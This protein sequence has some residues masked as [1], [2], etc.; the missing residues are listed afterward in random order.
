MERFPSA[1]ATPSLLPLA[2]CASQAQAGP[3]AHPLPTDPVSFHEVAFDVKAP[4]DRLVQ[5]FL[6]APLERF[7]KGTSK[8]PGVRHTEPLTDLRYPAVGSVRLVFL[9]DGNTAHEEV[10]TCDERQLRYFVTQY[11][12]PQAK[13]VS[14]GLGEFTFEPAADA[15]TRVRW[16]YSFKLRPDTFPGWL[17]GI[18]RALFRWQFVDRDYA[19]FMNAQV[20]E[21][22][23]FG[24]HEVPR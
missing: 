22:Q 3:P 23:E 7:I 18:G 9:L 24:A 20:R 6:A 21:I 10:L 12:S 14:W 17:G 19:A 4:R 2:A 16:R 15:V 1:L 8:L 11:S 13:P 5:A